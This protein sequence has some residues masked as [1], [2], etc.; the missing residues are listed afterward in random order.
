MRARVGLLLLLALSACERKNGAY[1]DDTR[2]CAGGLA[3]DPVAHECIS[4]SGVDLAAGTG[5]LAVPSDGG[6]PDLALNG[7]DLASATDGSF[8][9]LKSIDLKGVDLAG[10]CVTVMCTQGAAGDNFCKTACMNG[11]AKCGGNNRCIP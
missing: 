2:P 6:Q 3:C 7:D 4:A 5:D 10:T 11:N 8:V 1:C 9:D